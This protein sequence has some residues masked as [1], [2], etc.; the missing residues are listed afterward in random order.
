MA[1]PSAATFNSTYL[2]PPSGSLY[3]PTARGGTIRFRVA[4][5]VYVLLRLINEGNS[6]ATAQ[7]QIAARKRH[8]DNLWRAA[9]VLNANTI[10]TDFQSIT[11]P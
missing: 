2:D 9:G 11:G 7:A 4:N 6:A 8:M 3:A 1:T 10:I 5:A